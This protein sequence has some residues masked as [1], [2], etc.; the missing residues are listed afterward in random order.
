MD[1][2]V[3]LDTGVGLSVDGSMQI[4]IINNEFNAVSD[5]SGKILDDWDSYW[6]DLNA[7]LTVSRMVSDSVVK[8][9]VNAVVEEASEKVAL[10]EAELTLLSKRLMSCD[11]NVVG[12]NSS[13]S[14]LMMP[15]LSKMIVEPQETKLEFCSCYFDV[16]FDEKMS[17]LRVKSEEQLRRLK[18]EIRNVRGLDSLN[19]GKAV[20]R[21]CKIDDCVDVLESTLAAIYE[22][23]DGKFLSLKPV[24]AKQ[25]REDELQNEIG[26]IMVCLQDELEKGLH[27]QRTLMNTFNGKWQ[28]HVS[29]LSNLRQELDTI[30]RSLLSSEPGFLFSQSNT[31]T[32]EEWNNAK[33]KDHISRNVVGN[34]LVSCL[35]HS[36][37]NWNPQTDKSD[38]FVKPTLDVTDSPLLKHMTKEELIGY[39]KTE[40]TKMKRQHESAL[41]EMTEEL[42]SCKRELLKEKGSNLSHFRKDKEFELPRKKILEFLGRLDAMLLENDE[43]PIV[44]EDQDI[45]EDFKNKMHTVLASAKRKDGVCLASVTSYPAHQTTHHS[46]LGIDLLKQ[47][48]KLE[49]DIADMK[50]EASITNEVQKIALK[51]L[52]DEIESGLEDEEMENKFLQE[53]YSTIY[54]G[55]ILHGLSSIHPAVNKWCEEKDSMQ[56]ILLEKETSLS[57]KIEENEK[58]EQVISTLSTRL[59]EKENFASEAVSKLTEQKE[60][61]HLASQE[62]EGLRGI[63]S[64]QEALIIENKIESDSTKSRLDE[65]L[66]QIQDYKVEINKLD[67]NVKLLKDALDNTEKEQNILHAI[68]QEKD[69]ALS[70]V[71]SKEKEQTEHMKSIISSMSE[72][73]RIIEDYKCRLTCNIGKNESRLNV[74][75]QQCSQLVQQADLCKR[76]TLWCKQKYDIIYSD[77]HKAEIEVDLLGNEV[78][79]LLTVLEMIYIALDHYSNVLQYYP[80]VMEILD[81]LRRELKK[82]YS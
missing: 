57:L 55:A 73:S 35:P 53:I 70:S 26:S 17:R 74:L 7:R 41:Q 43:L 21:F 9:I 29:E 54:T 18:D 48:E 47:I 15:E 34:H 14:V 71:V 4:G 45:L 39:H 52:V 37:E 66:L 56:A 75:N 63:V 51:E 82:R 58:L 2:S 19:E 49:L 20:E 40:M 28:K 23:I 65:A 8:G 68:I 80:G 79:A 59:T 13:Q 32:L 42:F 31:E 11:S 76:E 25:Q 3:I 77:F 22:S 24:A 60:H 16:K 69:E 78:D 6:D 81:L 30:S 72:L 61:V 36:A 27:E 33:R 1:S 46:P 62:L 5:D 50:I 10:K 67:Q 44:T 12:Y 38:G 64:E